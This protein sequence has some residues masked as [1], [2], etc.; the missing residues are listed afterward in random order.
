ML[1]LEKKLFDYFNQEVFRDDN[2]TAVS[3]TAAP[4][5]SDPGPPPTAGWAL[6]G[7][8]PASGQAAATC[9]TVFDGQH[10][11]WHWGPPR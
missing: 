2:G 11:P 5:S 6:T 9:L 3:P 7:V 10:G 4:G 1:Q 8:P